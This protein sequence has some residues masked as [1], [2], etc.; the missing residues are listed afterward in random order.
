M[1]D[2]WPGG[3]GQEGLKPAIRDFIGWKQHEPVYQRQPDVINP[4]GNVEVIQVILDG[5]D[6]VDLISIKHTR[7]P[8]LLIFVI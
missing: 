1:G 5:I 3:N 6:P 4:M 7:Y 8:D 2:G